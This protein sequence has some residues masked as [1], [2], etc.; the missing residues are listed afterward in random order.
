VN[1]NRGTYAKDE[2]VFR[3]SSLYDRNREYFEDFQA[4]LR[5]HLLV[6]LQ[7]VERGELEASTTIKPDISDWTV[8]D[9]YGSYPQLGGSMASNSA[10]LLDSSGSSTKAD[11]SGGGAPTPASISA[12][13]YGN[14]NRIIAK[15]STTD[16]VSPELIIQLQELKLKQD[17]SNLDKARVTVEE[18][19]EVPVEPDVDS[20]SDSGDQE[21]D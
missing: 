8:T 2:K 16:Y 10:A 14:S 9:L 20:D 12:P 7:G 13:S 15:S 1:S 18:L 4:D 17:K 19:G 21:N 11:K 6:Y 5:K 3:A